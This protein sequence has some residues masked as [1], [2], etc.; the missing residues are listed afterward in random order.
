MGRFYGKVL[1]GTLR[2]FVESC[3]NLEPHEQLALWE[4]LALVRHSSLQSIAMY[5]LCCTALP[6][7]T[8]EQK[9]KKLERV[10]QA[11]DMMRVS[12]DQ[13]A[14]LSEKQANIVYQAKDKVTIHNIDYAVRQ[15]VALMWDCFGDLGPEVLARMQLLEARV[16]A[17]VKIA[18]TAEGTT[19][20]PDMDA[21]EMDSTV[22]RDE[23]GD[24]VVA[25]D[26]S[27][28]T[29]DEESNDVD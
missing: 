1:T 18:G 14:R 24:D 27:H 9:E 21:R 16:R 22:P 2:E 23:S 29:E 4:E 7:E 28:I 6:E 25:E 20:T 5:N 10:M 15:V 12:I 8:Q 19:L 11:A 3:C 26:V 17:E 13:V